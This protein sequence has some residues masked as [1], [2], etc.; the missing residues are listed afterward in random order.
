MS[1]AKV[2]LVGG[3][4]GDPGL[5]T[6]K[7]LDCI[8]Q[9]DV[10]VY[11]YLVDGRLVDE[12]GEDCERVY[13]GKKAG[14]HTLRQEEINDLLVE[15][16]KRGKVVV[17]LKGGDPFVFGRGGEEALALSEAGVEFEVVPGVTAAVAA[18]AYAGIP[19]THRGLTSTLALITGH[20]DPT[21]EGSDI[22]WSSIS[23]GIGTLVFFMGVGNLPGIVK[24]L[25][26]NGR[27]Q[28]TPVALIRWGTKP[29]QM[30]VVGSLRDIVEKVESHDLKPPAVIVVGDVV[31]LRENLNWFENKPL[32]GMRILVT[33]SRDQASE[34]SRR[35]EDFG[36]LAMEFPTISI[37]EPHDWR[38]LDNAIRKIVSFDWIVFTSANGVDKFFLRFFQ[39][40][41]DI[42]KL[43]GIKICA[44]GPASAE[45]IERR[46]IKVDLL[47]ESNTSDSIVSAFGK[48]GNISGLKFL[49]PRADIAGDFLPDHLRRT[50]A[51]VVNVAAY[52]N[53]R[54]E[55]V[56]DGILA[57]LKEGKVDMMTFASS[58]TV[59]N[60]AD[61]IGKE[62]F[63]DI[64]NDVKVASI[65]PVTSRTI[66]ELGGKIDIEAD[67]NNI[68]IPGL[69]DAIVSYY[70][71]LQADT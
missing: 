27:S 60:I 43:G 59:K 38:P 8:K 22:D 21:K 2:Y 31:K 69:V 10:L 25:V 34:L 14:E 64:I 29:C 62:R 51:E 20:E 44:I 1:R 52:R 33:R 23:T 13:M 61:I 57:L 49:L 32:F 12:A 7:G 30:T 50:G 28:D 24:K 71:R 6:L 67:E 11:D 37:K 48:M 41:G 16:A 17:R 47:P 56:D 68:T 3:G 15:R 58:S 9:A 45:R 35:L 54:P 66:L 5:I 65:G 63:K 4:P 42:R 46:Y 55:R 18:P 40:V 26:E 53:V 39:L 36:A 70:S 19:L